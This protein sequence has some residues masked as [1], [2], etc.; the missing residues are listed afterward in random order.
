MKILVVCGA[1][2]SSTFVALKL[3]TAAAARGVEAN[4]V[5]GSASQL[6]SYAGVDVVL[7]GAHLSPQLPALQELA[8]SSGAAVAVLP[9]VSPAAIDGSAALD[10]ALDAKAAAL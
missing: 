7:V 10:L 2:A 4:V 8:A 1:G 5:A 6:E 9:A 3:R